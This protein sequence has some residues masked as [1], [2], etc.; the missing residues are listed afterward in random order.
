LAKSNRLEV[1]PDDAGER[2]LYIDVV[3]HQ[4]D[5]CIRDLRAE[6][7]QGRQIGREDY[8]RVGESAIE[9]QLQHIGR[10]VLHA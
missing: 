3:K 7:L 6:V 5:P 10:Q 2:R 1:V 4:T 8:A 9:N